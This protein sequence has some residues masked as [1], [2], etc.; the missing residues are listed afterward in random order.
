MA[1]DLGNVRLNTKVESVIRRTDGKDTIIDIT[2][3]GETDRYKALIIATDLQAA[4]NY[5]DAGTEEKALFQQVINYN[6]Y[7]HLV[8]AESSYP[9]GSFLFLDEYGA[10]PT[11]GHMTALINRPYSQGLWTTGQLLPWDS[12]LDDLNEFLVQD[13]KDLQADVGQTIVQKQWTYFPHVNSKSL[14]A[15]FYPRLKALQGNNN[16]F[17][18]GGILNFETVESTAAFAKYLMEEKF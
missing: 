16:T 12:T 11:I 1:E 6:Y 3:G 4:L 17:Y 10:A 15:G 2:A 5:L 8:E 14:D 9:G 18:V 7:I 13:F